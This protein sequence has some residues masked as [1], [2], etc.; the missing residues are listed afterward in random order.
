MYVKRVQVIQKWMLLNAIEAWKDIDAQVQER[1]GGASQ[2]P[3]ERVVKR[4][5]RG[6]Q[7]CS[8]IRKR[9]RHPSQT[10]AARHHE[11]RRQRI[12]RERITNMSLPQYGVLC[13]R[14]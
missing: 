12:P 4:T 1:D 9:L 3:T 11:S 5:E 14:D 6:L 8:R 7:Q 10:R 13:D 2:L